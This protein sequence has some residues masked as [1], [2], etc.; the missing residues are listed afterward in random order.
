MARVGDVVLLDHPADAT[1][2]RSINCYLVEV[3]DFTAAPIGSFL[4]F[5]SPKQ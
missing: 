4:L 5:R 3:Q 1:G 2:P